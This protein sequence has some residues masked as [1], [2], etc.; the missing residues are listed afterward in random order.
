[1]RLSASLPA[2]CSPWSLPGLAALLLL[3]AASAVDLVRNHPRR[4]PGRL[5]TRRASGLTDVWGYAR[6]TDN[7]FAHVLRWLRALHTFGARSKT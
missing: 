5:P 7:G 4:R 1:M 6:E 2:F 3:I